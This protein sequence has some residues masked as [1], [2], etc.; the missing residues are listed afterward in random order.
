MPRLRVAPCRR[1]SA[2]L[3][4]ASSRATEEGGRAE[5]R[6]QE[7]GAQCEAMGARRWAQGHTC[8]LDTRSLH[9]RSLALSPARWARSPR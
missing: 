9:A 4:R 1:P 7:E 6:G 3:L 8:S 2:L 5:G